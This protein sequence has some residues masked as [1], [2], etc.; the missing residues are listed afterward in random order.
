MKKAINITVKVLVIIPLSV[1][2]IAGIFYV[3]TKIY[4][5]PV[6]VPF[7]GSEYYNP[8]RKITDH[9]LKGNLHAHGYSWGGLTN[10]HDEPEKIY[11]FYENNGYEVV[12]ISNYHRVDKT[13]CDSTSLKMPVYEHGY[14]LLK[15]HNL[16]INPTK[17]SFF[18]YPLW[19]MTSH[20]QHVIDKMKDNDAKVVIAHP[21]LFNSKTS[22]DLSKLCNYDFIEVF[23]HYY[24]SEE[25]WDRALSAGR[26][27]WGLSSDDIHALS[28]EPVCK[29]WNVIYAGEKSID[30]VMDAMDSGT[31]YMVKSQDGEFDNDLKSCRV[32]DDVLTVTFK[33]K[34]D[35]IRLKGKQGVLLKEVRDT[36][37]VSYNITPCDTYVRTV[38]STGSDQ[39][40]LNPVI[41]SFSSEIKPEF[42]LSPEVN[43]TATWLF[44]IGTVI[45]MVA[46]AFLI[47]LVIKRL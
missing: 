40:L 5:F 42:S 38:A 15:S 2:L 28:D 26:V 4:R 22:Y 20:K 33:R 23:N 25:P 19:Q 10:G 7:S 29:R 46:Q 12:G 41:K 18:D 27:V 3:R 13:S 45:F 24:D 16:A 44:R 37:A 47:R 17:T 39:L 21:K 30:G 14:N 11:E 6:E 35:H 36:N 31:F 8:Y 43:Q 1:L 32:V 9:K 34:L